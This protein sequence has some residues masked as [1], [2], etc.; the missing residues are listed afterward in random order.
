MTL[1]NSLFGQ[2][3]NLSYLFVAEVGDG[4]RLLGAIIS[5]KFCLKTSFLPFFMDF[6]LKT[7][8]IVVRF[9]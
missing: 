2:H 8:E 7:A 1:K 6:S 4:D 3:A 9:M 5:F